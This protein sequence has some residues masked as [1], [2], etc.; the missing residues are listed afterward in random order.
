MNKETAINVEGFLENV[1]ISPKL[2]PIKSISDLPLKLDVYQKMKLQYLVSIKSD[3][4]KLRLNYIV[5]LERDDNSMSGL[6][7]LYE[8]DDYI[9]NYNKYIVLLENKNDYKNHKLYNEVISLNQLINS[10]NENNSILEKEFHNLNF[11][12]NLVDFNSYKD[13]DYSLYYQPYNSNYPYKLNNKKIVD[14]YLIYFKPTK[15]KNFETSNNK[16]FNVSNIDCSK[17]HRENNPIFS[18]NINEVINKFSDLREIRKLIKENIELKRK[19]SN[20][21]KE[22]INWQTYNDDLDKDQQDPNF[23]NQF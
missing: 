1:Q 3:T 15:F 14:N 6:I 12:S 19:K 17:I 5:F 11:E 18:G 2:D 22:N 4:K 20:N 21:I 16:I 8:K 7:D 13:F 10:F 23:W 9:I